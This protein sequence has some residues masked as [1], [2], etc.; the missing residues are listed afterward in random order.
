[1]C[2]L[3]PAELVSQPEEKHH[4]GKPERNRNSGKIISRYSEGILH[5]V[6]Q[7]HYCFFHQEYTHQNS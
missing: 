4:S 1:M 2:V 5:G 3:E 7:V 6:L